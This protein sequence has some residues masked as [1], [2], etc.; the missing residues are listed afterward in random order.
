MTMMTMTESA[1]PSS[2]VHSTPQERLDRESRA[3]RTLFVTGFAAFTSLFGVIAST[4]SPVVPSPPAPATASEFSSGRRV[5]A[6]VPL[7]EGSS[8][9]RRE[10]VVRIVAP[11]QQAPAPHVRT[12]ATP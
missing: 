9:D 10:T 12:R 11:D 1:G 6:E 4:A 8:L 7:S 5:V 3:R 2:R